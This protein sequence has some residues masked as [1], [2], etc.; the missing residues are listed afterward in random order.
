LIGLCINCC[1]RIIY[2]G[3]STHICNRFSSYISTY[4]YNKFFVHQHQE[5]T[6]SGSDFSREIEISSNHDIEESVSLLG[7]SY[8]H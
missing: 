8:E 7:N 3:I 4:I 2:Y 1:C 5:S 6:Q